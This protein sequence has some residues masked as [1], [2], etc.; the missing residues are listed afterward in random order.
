MKNS[1][2]KTLTVHLTTAATRLKKRTSR[3]L[4]EAG[5]E[6]AVVVEAAEETVAV[7]EAVAEEPG[8]R[9]L[10]SKMTSDG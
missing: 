5:A 9:P 2:L 4:T 3:L 1:T 8:D 10:N 6:A 7:V